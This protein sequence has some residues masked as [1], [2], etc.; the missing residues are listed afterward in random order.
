M[1]T[2]FIHKP[3]V[4]GLLIAAG[5]GLMLYFLPEEGNTKLKVSY[6]G[7]TCEAPISAPL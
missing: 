5:L 4:V 7:L 2:E 1:F 6:I 3:V